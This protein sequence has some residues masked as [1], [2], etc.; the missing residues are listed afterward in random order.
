MKQVCGSVRSVL[1]K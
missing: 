1:K